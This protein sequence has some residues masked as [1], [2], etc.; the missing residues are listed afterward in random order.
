MQFAY[1]ILYLSKEMGLPLNLLKNLTKASLLFLV[2]PI[3]GEGAVNLPS[4]G[5][6]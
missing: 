3:Q 6:F 2:K 4:E 1:S 5:Y